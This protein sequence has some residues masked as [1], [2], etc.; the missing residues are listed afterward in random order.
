MQMESQLN[1]NGL[2]ETVTGFLGTE[3]PVMMDQCRWE[4]QALASENEVLRKKLS[5][6]EL[7]NRTLNENLLAKQ[8]EIREL[9]SQLEELRVL[10]QDSISA[11]REYDKYL[12]TVGQVYSVACESAD[13]IVM[14]AEK[15]ARKILE[16]LEVKTKQTRDNSEKTLLLLRKMRERLSDSLPALIKNLQNAYQEAESFYASVESVPESFGNMLSAQQLAL[17]DIKNQMEEY[18]QRSRSI[19]DGAMCSEGNVSVTESNEKT[20]SGLR[21]EDYSKTA[22]ATPVSPVPPETP[23]P[24]QESEPLTEA[25]RE[26]RPRVEGRSRMTLLE[27]EKLRRRKEMEALAKLHA[28]AA[29]PAAEQTEEQ[30]PAPAAEITRASVPDSQPEPSATADRKRRTNVKDLLDKY[31]N[32]QLL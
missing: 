4:N 9:Q 11:R 7:S 14:R 20:L 31:K 27:Q 26:E 13:S 15:S 29:A 25:V 18:H 21:D 8:F 24:L 22:T 6:M 3:S 30:P 10:Y 1:R 12:D 5:A 2:N 19:M 23:E 28:E 16:E 17:A 32:Y